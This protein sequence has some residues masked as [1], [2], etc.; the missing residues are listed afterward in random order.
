MFRTRTVGSNPSEAATQRAL[1]SHVATPLTVKP[2]GPLSRGG[3]LNEE[4]GDMRSG[5]P[6]C[7]DKFFVGAFYN[8]TIF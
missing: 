2:H 5:R 4:K 1:Q 8:L 3:A 6:I 7:R